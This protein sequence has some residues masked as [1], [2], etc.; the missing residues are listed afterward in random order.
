MPDSKIREGEKGE[1][2][3]EGE[4]LLREIECVGM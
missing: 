3:T 4:T 1:I 2:K